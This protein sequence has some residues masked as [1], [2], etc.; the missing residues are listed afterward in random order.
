MKNSFQFLDNS[1]NETSGDEAMGAESESC[2][3]EEV[4]MVSGPKDDGSRR[5]D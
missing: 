2:Q 3:E 4:V 5:R 1:K